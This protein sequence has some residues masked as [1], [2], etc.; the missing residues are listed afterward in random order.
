[1]TT[2]VLILIG[3]AALALAATAGAASMRF[4]VLHN[5]DS[6]IVGTK[7]IACTVNNNSITFGCTPQRSGSGTT[8]AS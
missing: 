4:V 6:A 8:R 2:K 3:I 5:G 7:K 1:M